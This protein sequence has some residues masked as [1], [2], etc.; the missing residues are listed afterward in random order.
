[1][2][3]LRH[4]RLVAR[5]YPWKRR[6]RREGKGGEGK[7]KGKRKGKEKRGREREGREKEERNMVIPTLTITLIVHIL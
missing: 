6:K 1:V 2:V 5:G 3:L 7:R 4:L